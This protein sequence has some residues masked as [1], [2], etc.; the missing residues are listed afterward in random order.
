[1][2]DVLNARETPLSETQIAFV[3]RESLKARGA[4]RAWHALACDARRALPRRA[5]ASIL[6][7]R[8]I[9]GLA[10]LHTMNKVHRDIKCSNILLTGAWWH[11]AARLARAMLRLT[12]AR[13]G[14]PPRAQRAAK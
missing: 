1:M 3:C 7:V 13:A 5:D 8:H 14:P 11:G 4:A 10:Y 6:R 12:R 9:Q 2:R